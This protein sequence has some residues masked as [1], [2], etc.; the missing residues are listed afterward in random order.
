[1][2]DLSRNFAKDQN[3]CVVNQSIIPIISLKTTQG[4]LH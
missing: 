2:F 4:L 1:M 3:K